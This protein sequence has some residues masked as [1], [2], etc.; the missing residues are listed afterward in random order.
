[1]SQWKDQVM[2]PLKLQT[3]VKQKFVK[4]KQPTVGRY[5]IGIQSKGHEGRLVWLA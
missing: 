3:E 4:I 1:M 2:N 5:E